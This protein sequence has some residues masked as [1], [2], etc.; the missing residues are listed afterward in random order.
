[1]HWPWSITLLGLEPGALPWFGVCHGHSVRTGHTQAIQ[2]WDLLTFT[3]P[4]F[5][6][7]CFENVSCWINEPLSSCV[8]W[9]CLVKNSLTISWCWWWHNEMWCSNAGIGR[10]HCLTSFLHIFIWG[11]S[12]RASPSLLLLLHCFRHWYDTVLLA[13]YQ[14]CHQ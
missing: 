5:V 14:S 11:H 2:S 8:L 4:C 9:S 10:H 3:F 13:E 7:T 12:V 1:M 6:L